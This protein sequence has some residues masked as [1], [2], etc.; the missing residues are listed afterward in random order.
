MYFQSVHETDVIADG[1]IDLTDDT[2]EEHV[3][4]GNH[5]VKFFAP[6]CSHCQVSKIS[7]LIFYNRKFAMGL[8]N[9][10][11]QLEPYT[12]SNQRQINVFDI[13]STLT[14]LGRT[15]DC[16]HGLREQLHLCWF[17]VVDS[18]R[19]KQKAHRFCTK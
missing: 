3:A 11:G 19:N 10:V 5:F 8:T 2:F 1:L 4:L 6:W 13:T 9:H 16:N 14:V 18:E 7:R 17:S 15:L 12:G